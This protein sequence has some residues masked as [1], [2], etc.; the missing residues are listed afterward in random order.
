M[1]T[2]TEN[3]GTCQHHGEFYMDAPD[4]PCPSCED[5]G[6][7]GLV[8]YLDKPRGVEDS[9]IETARVQERERCIAALLT[10]PSICGG[11]KER[12]LDPAGFIRELLNPES[13]YQTT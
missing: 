1:A 7:G 9:A 8:V 11:L 5:V 13:A 10:Q 4:S 12:H 6:P 3:I 2:K